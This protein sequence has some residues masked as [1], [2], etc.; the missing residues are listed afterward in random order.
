MGEPARSPAK[1]CRARSY[2]PGGVLWPFSFHPQQATRETTLDQGPHVAGL[3]VPSG[4][5]V[6]LPSARMDPANNS[7]SKK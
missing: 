7:V 6:A 3:A 4:G 5:G 1:A 2:V